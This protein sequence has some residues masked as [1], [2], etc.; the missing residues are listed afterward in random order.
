M[1]KLSIQ[2]LSHPYENELHTRYCDE[3]LTRLL[4][5]MFHPPLTNEEGILLVQNRESR[6]SAGIH[7]LFMRSNLTIVWINSNKK[8]VDKKLAVRWHP[9]YIPEKPALY[10]LE[11]SP[12]R[13]TDFNLD[14]EL[15][16]KELD[17]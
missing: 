8:V 10:V 4:G 15:A 9:Y 16:F 6:I 7:M 2:N 11:C 5:L 12:T 13:F 1:K 14:D 3:F 17:G